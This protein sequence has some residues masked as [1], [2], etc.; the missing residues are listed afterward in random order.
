MDP[1]RA[2]PR[3]GSALI[4][5]IDTCE[6]VILSLIAG[7]AIPRVNGET[8]IADLRLACRDAQTE[9]EACSTLQRWIRER[10]VSG[11]LR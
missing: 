6:L 4:T 1:A 11:I 7:G 8:A 10:I 9:L 2:G 5:S 3:D